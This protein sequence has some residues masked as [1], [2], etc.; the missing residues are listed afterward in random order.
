MVIYK[1][2][3]PWN[4]SYSVSLAAMVAVSF[5]DSRMTLSWFLLSCIICFSRFVKTFLK[6]FFFILLH[7]SLKL[8]NILFSSIVFFL[9]K[10]VVWARLDLQISWIV[11]LYYQPIFRIR[12]L[13]TCN[14]VEF[15]YEILFSRCGSLSA[16]IPLSRRR[17]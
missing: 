6:P 13:Q 4:V 3:P 17:A 9:I 16:T 5:C 2:F 11:E 10:R 14:S 1:G 8:L 12:Y 15:P 7:R